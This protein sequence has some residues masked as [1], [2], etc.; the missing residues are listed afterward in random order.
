MT[1]M[2]EMFETF[3]DFIIASSII[4]GCSGAFLGFCWG[5]HRIVEMGIK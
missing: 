4:V 2:S 3:K 5:L 1:M